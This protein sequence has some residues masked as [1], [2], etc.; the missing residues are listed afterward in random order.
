MWSL[1][2]AGGHHRGEQEVH[3][4]A[5]RSCRNGQP[6]HTLPRSG[7]EYLGLLLLIKNTL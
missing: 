7:E 3:G 2:G 4:A 6:L 5:A 1:H